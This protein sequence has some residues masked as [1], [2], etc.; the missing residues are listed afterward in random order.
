[1][2]DPQ[3]LPRVGIALILGLFVLSF[4]F[5]MRQNPAHYED[6]WSEEVTRSYGAFLIGVSILGVAMYLVRLSRPEEEADE[7][8]ERTPV[9]V[10]QVS[11]SKILQTKDL[12][13]PISMVNLE[14]RRIPH[15]IG[16][17]GGVPPKVEIPVGNFV[18]GRSPSCD[19]V[20][21]SQLVSRKHVRLQWD[22]HVLKIVDLG[23]SNTAVVNDE[24]LVGEK[25]LQDGDVIQIV[26]YQMEVSLSL[27]ESLDATVIRTKD[28]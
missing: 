15:L 6:R 8:P 19:M 18:I 4:G 1:M 11:Q 22:G 5:D 24:D 10:E 25:V 3:K 27:P 14:P 13:Q 20:L 12:N 17:T 9:L 2:F 23:S 7:T 16:I 21:S 28:S 26:D